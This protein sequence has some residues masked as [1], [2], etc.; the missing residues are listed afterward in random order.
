VASWRSRIRYAHGVN[1]TEQS[2]VFGYGEDNVQRAG[3]HKV[4]LWV[5]GMSA[6]GRWLRVAAGLC[7]GLVFQHRGWADR[8]LG[9]PSRTAIYPPCEAPAAVAR[10]GVYP[11][12]LPAT[13]PAVSRPSAGARCGHP[14]SARF[15]TTPPA[16]RRLQPYNQQPTQSDARCVLDPSS[17]EPAA[18]REGLLWA[19][20]RLR[21]PPTTV[22]RFVIMKGHLTNELWRH[23]RGGGWFGCLRRIAR[24][25]RNFISHSLETS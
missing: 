22:E 3:T 12:P 8:L 23:Y 18:P 15:E 16:H 9:G 2:G 19:R 11:L 14:R 21:C 20:S 7:A 1:F 17:A 25:K 10:R 24:S 6:G 4:R 5:D 13:R